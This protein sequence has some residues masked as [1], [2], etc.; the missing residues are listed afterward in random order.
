VSEGSAAD[1]TVKLSN[2]SATDTTV[3]LNL[4]T[5]GG[6]GNASSADVGGLQYK[7]PHVYR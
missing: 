3:T 2:P 1:F 7:D 5:A 6:A 4:V